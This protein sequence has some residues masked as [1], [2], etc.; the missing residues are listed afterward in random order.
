MEKIT[1]SNIIHYNKYKN[2]RQLIRKNKI[3]RYI[4][5]IDITLLTK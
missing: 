2:K 3:T 4:R 1:K 5:K